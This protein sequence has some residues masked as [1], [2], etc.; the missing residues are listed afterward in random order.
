MVSRFTAA[1]IPVGTHAIGDRAIDWVVDTYA[2]SLAEH[3]IAHLRHSII[4][5]NVPSEHALTLMAQLQQQYDAAIPEAQGPFTWW[6]GDNYAG[7]FGPVRS[8]RLNPFATY[9]KRG[10]LWAGGSDY[11]VTPLPARYGLW[12][13]IARAPLQGTYGARP[14]GEQ[15]AVT[16]KTALKSYTQWAA[17]QLFLE[18]ETGTLEAGKSADVAIWEQNPLVI[19]AAQI[20]S[21]HCAMTLYRGRVVWSDGTLHPTTHRAHASS[22]R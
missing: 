12:A 4:H 22:K 6:I 21:L 7:N 1:G 10:I 13:S 19:P 14:F 16:I 3:P 11:D 18:N 9:L 5:A 20:K 2:T 8:Q 17:R 15:E